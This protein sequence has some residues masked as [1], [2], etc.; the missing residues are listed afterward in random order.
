MRQETSLF[1]TTWKV[2]MKSTLYF[3]ETW[4]Y[5][6]TSPC[7]TTLLWLHNGRDGVLNHQPHDCLLNRLFR[8][9]S[10]KTSKIR[11]TGVCFRGIHWWPVNSPHKW[12]VTRKIFPFDDVI[13]FIHPPVFTTENTLTLGGGYNDSWIFLSNE[14]TDVNDLNIW[15]KWKLHDEKKRITSTFSS[16]L[17]NRRHMPSHDFHHLFCPFI[18]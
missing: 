13:M 15:S 5:E 16:I 6:I 1:D 12:Q 11:V 10:K 9:R 4:Y 3:A 18:I 17:K 14:T 8:H 7:N 2:W